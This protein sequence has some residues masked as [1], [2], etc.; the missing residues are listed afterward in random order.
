MQDWLE[1]DQSTSV[2][3]T[4]TLFCGPLFSNCILNGCDGG[5]ISKWLLRFMIEWVCKECLSLAPKLV[6]EEPF[7]L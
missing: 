7:Q 3:E 1:E 6:V 5:R 4:H 2:I